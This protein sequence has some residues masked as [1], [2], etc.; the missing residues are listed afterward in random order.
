MQTILHA[1]SAGASANRS[2]R[3]P[4]SGFNSPRFTPD[5]IVLDRVLFD[6]AALAAASG[7]EVAT[8]AGRR[9]IRLTNGLKLALDVSSR[10]LA[11]GDQIVFAVHVPEKQG[12]NLGLR[13]ETS[14]RTEGI[15]GPDY[16]HLWG[17]S[18]GAGQRR[19]DYGWG[20]LLCPVENFH[21][22]GIPDG[23]KR[24]TN[25]LLNCS[26][27]GDG[28][29]LSEIRLQKRRKPAGPRLTDAGL[30]EFLDLERRELA[31]VR[32]AYAR[33]DLAQALAALVRHFRSRHNP[34]HIYA[35]KPRSKN[36]N[37]AAA[38]RICEHFIQGQQLAKVIDWR[39]NPIGYLEW[40]HAFNRHYFMNPLLDAYH[41]TGREKYAAELDA[42]LRSWLAANPVPLGHNGGGDPAW[43]TLSTAVRI[44][45]TWL[46]LFFGL[47]A[48]PS[49]QA[50]TRLMMLKSL[51]EHAEHLMERSVTL[52]R[53][54]WLI[55]ESE[56]IALIG[57]LFPEFRRAGAWRAEG[58]RRL[59]GEMRAQV[60]PDGAQFELSPGYHMMSISGFRDPWQVARLNRLA[61]PRGFERR[62]VKAHESIL[63]LARPDLALPS[64][65]DSGGCSPSGGKGIAWLA[66]GGR[67]FR[68]PD[69]LWV[70]AGRAAGRPPAFRSIAFDHAGYYVMRSGWTP[71]DR[72]LFF[73]AGSLGQ[74]H[75]HEDKLNFELYAYGQP[76]I[77]DPGITGY[78][79]EKWTDY[80]RQTRAHNTLLLDGQ[81]QARM[82]NDAGVTRGQSVA[83]RNT[84]AKSGTVELASAEYASGYGNLPGRFVHRRAILFV[85]GLYW[86]L[87]DE[88]A[89]EGEHRIEALFHFRPGRVLVDAGQHCLRT[90]RPS[91]PNLDLLLWPQC[92]DAGMKI[93]CGEQEPVQ[94]WLSI[95]GEDVPSPV[96]IITRSGPLPL[97]LALLM[98]PYNT[99]TESRFRTRALPAP[100][101]VWAC[102]V[103]R[104]DGR[105]D[106]IG[107]RWHRTA[108]NA[109]YSI[110]GVATGA[111]VL[112]LQKSPQGAE[113]KSE[114]QIKRGP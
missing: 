54:N 71:D 8:A 48:S 101:E 29:L 35:P 40:M 9:G 79:A 25:M 14:T 91:H 95:G 67:L 2:G 16:F 99:G 51:C 13:L 106:C 64:A 12:L 63:A 50:E 22:Y 109:C 114:L 36:Y 70:G 83:G 61:I 86:L 102:E 110:M 45:S 66:E 26:A 100:D 98:V 105:V 78:M 18:K 24:L 113:R 11:E 52:F 10:N 42:L 43:E 74:S 4:G 88:M 58:W 5:Q 20:G 53:N 69:L 111:D 19:P 7:A 49:F 93:V 94:G 112:V 23:W 38:D 57:M 46:R 33:G 72:Y 107:Y 55:V 104:P 28:I 103:A 37:P 81:G 77:L 82:A 34:R 1:D 32:K 60:F 47:Q 108:A 6:C 92:A 68:R 85:D 73:D 75:C 90:S 15:Q 96:G 31:S 3:D 62:L 27:D 17:V 80:Y 44:Y 39:A 30:L 97:R 59:A 56:A 41:A 89:G 76:L 84:W 87:F 65:N 21:I